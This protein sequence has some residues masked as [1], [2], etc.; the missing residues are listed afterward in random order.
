MAN[1][2][3][4]QLPNING[5]LTS[6]ALMPIVSTNG[7]FI[8]D[9][10]TVATLANF[11]LGESGNLFVSADLA[12]LSYNVVNAAQPNITS[13]GTLTGLTVVG[14]SNIGYPNN[15]VILGGVPGQ[16]L[17]TFGNG[18]LGWTDN[19]G[20]TGAT[21][22]AGIV[23]SNTAPADTSVLW[24]NPNTP[25]TLG[26]GSTGATGVTGATGN[27]GPVGAV[28]GTGATGIT[29][30]TGLTGATGDTGPIGATGATGAVGSTGATGIEGPT[31]ATGVQGSTGPAGTSVN[32]IGSVPTA[33]VDPQLTLN[34]A[35]PSAVDG[36]GVLTDDTGDLWVL[37]GGLWT[38]V[39]N[40][41]GPEGSTGATGP[42]GATGIQGATG[43]QG[44]TGTQGATGEQGTTGPQ[45]ATGST[46]ETGSTG[47]TGL[48]GI[49]ESNTAPVD[50]SI[51]WL[52]TDTPG[53]LGIG[54][55]GATG[56]NGTIGVDGSTGA[57]GSTG[58]TGDTGATGIAG[59]TGPQGATGIGST[60]ATGVP[61]IV[62][63]NTAPVDTSI[64][65]LN[66][67]TPGTLGVGATGATGAAGTIGVDGST[68]AT[69]ASG[70]G[71]V[72]QGAWQPIPTTY[73]GG[74]DVVSYAG[75]SYI[76]IGDGNSG[77]APPDDPAR[78]GVVADPGST[79]A[80]G[81]TG[82]TGVQGATGV[83]GATGSFSGTLTANLDANS[84]S[85]SNVGNLTANGNITAN[86][87]SGNITIVGNV[88]GTSPNVTL[89]AGSYSTVF[90]NTGNIVLPGNTFSVNYANGSAVNPVTRFTGSWTVPA[91]SSTQSFSVPI[92]G[93]YTLWIR[94]NIPNGIITYTAT[95]VVTNTNVPVL[96]D[97][98]GWY[99][100]IGN[101]LVL[102]SLPNQFTGTA[103]SIS[104]V[105][106]Y[107]G[108]TANVF[109]FGITNNSGGSC[110][111]EY[112]Y[113]Q[114]G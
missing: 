32:I 28:G 90:D 23:E 5:N 98:Y 94:G 76:K 112:G 73:V 7:T 89:V 102:T 37:A 56:A 44:S 38:D 79:G 85:I 6:S 110:T 42:Q 25:G 49:V 39:G 75:G 2:K 74:R 11:I 64:L 82:A 34:T 50:T 21:G 24:L 107:V 13:V 81:P 57:T 86:N 45:G 106:T 68:G 54:A 18:S 33:G 91:G 17:G 105:N 27:M 29:G 69:G 10:V 92:N 103:G 36:N 87:F 46:G 12:N 53:T 71:F 63:S 96:G 59:P 40:I 31:G 95:A 65:W 109:T 62:E 67:D 58:P 47:A 84:F 3:I 8:T 93:S 99:Y 78:W 4:S 55:T 60:G 22:P 15:V 43:A 111:I 30:S 20:N 72:W 52:N 66:T 113:I 48:A 77:S 108:N 26:I 88:T 83:T 51:L 114:I 101:A 100:V 35:F 14:T 97:Q 19:S 41:K 70:S 80:T 9:K 1:I 61:G 104:N 16:I